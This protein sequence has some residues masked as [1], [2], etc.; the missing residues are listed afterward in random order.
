M[1]DVTLCLAYYLN[2]GMLKEQYRILRA[3]PD[4]IKAHLRLIVVDDCSPDP[5]WVEAIGL[6]LWLYRM[7]KDIAWNQDA[8]RNLAVREAETDWVLM[9]DMDHVV[10]EETWRAVLSGNLHENTAYRFARV[11]MPKRDP[12]K[13]HPNTWL[14]TKS[15]FEKAGGYD[16]RFAGFYG[17]DGDFLG[18]LRSQAPILEMKEHVIRYPREV[19]KDASTTTLDRKT[20]ANG[21]AIKRIKAERLLEADARPKRYLTPWERIA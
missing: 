10:P 11:S 19:I 1:R 20:E 7:Q 14:M 12:Y 4:N 6:P 3:M 18:R 17:T 9:T 8:C 15:V 21:E 2:R 13:I 16:E 5:A